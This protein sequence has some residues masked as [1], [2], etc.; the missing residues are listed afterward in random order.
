MTTEQTEQTP[1]Q[2][3]IVRLTSNTDVIGNVY[4]SV[5]DQAHTFVVTNP[6]MLITT[7]VV[8]ESEEGEQHVRYEVSLGAYQPYAATGVTLI[9]YHAVESVSD[10][11][12]YMLVSYERWRNSVVNDHYDSDDDINAETLTDEG[13]TIH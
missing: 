9:P 8:E 7:P 2:L 13:I 10:I 4:E 6:A 12:Q 1:T 5:T 11:D 3:R